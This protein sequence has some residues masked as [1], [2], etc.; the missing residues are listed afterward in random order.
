MNEDEIID[1]FSIL[2]WLQA[3]LEVAKG[4]QGQAQ[5]DMLKESI[6]AVVDKVYQDYPFLLDTVRKAG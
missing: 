1:Q 4:Y 5:A 2:G 3:S 6:Q